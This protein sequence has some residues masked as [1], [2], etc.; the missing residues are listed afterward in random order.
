M[1]SDQKISYAFPK[2]PRTL[3]G[4]VAIIAGAGA[5][6]DG[7]GNGRASAI[8]LADEGCNVVCVD[9]SL[10]LAQKTVDYIEAEGKAKT[11]AIQA[12][13]TNEK[14]CKRIVDTTLEKF[15]RLDILFNCVGHGGP[16]G[17]ALEV[18]MEAWA[19]SMDINVG[20]MVKMSKYAIPAMTKND[21]EWGYRG[22]I[23]NMGSV[24]GIRGGT[25]ALLYP[26]SKGAVVN[27]TRAMAHHHA[28]VGIR[29]NCVCPGMVRPAATLKPQVNLTNEF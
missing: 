21:D 11:F 1:A 29:V 10:P 13:V 24:A 16:P 19:K 20:S 9:I 8:L 14:D 4:K 5:I 28:S 2:P 23:I 3:A 17:T 18:D 7:I 6:D 12:D 27:L 15:G 25:P 26:T 22:V